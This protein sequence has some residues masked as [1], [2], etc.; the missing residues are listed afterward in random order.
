MLYDP[1][2]FSG[3][4]ASGSRASKLQVHQQAEAAVALLKQGS[5]G[6][7]SLKFLGPS[8]TIGLK[9]VPGTKE[10]GPLDGCITWQLSLRGPPTAHDFGT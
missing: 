3:F 4:Q 6:I 7:S 1:L 2:R 8:Q 5:L 9:R 10:F